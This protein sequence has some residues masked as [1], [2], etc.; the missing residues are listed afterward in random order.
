VNKAWVIFRWL[1]GAA[2]VGCAFFVLGGD[3]RRLDMNPHSP[4]HVVVGMF[5]LSGAVFWIIPETV[6]PVASFIGGCWAGLLFPSGRFNKPALSY[7][8]PEFYSREGRH[9]EAALEYL[10]ILRYYPEERKAYLGLISAY[11][12]SGHFKLAERCE[13]RFRKRFKIS[14]SRRRLIG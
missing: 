6:T 14:K 7:I 3:P 8:L 1:L 2:Q 11:Q 12:I 5:L 13:A 4:V 9:E 10:K